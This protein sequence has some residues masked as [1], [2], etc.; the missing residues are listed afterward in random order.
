MSWHRVF[1][2]GPPVPLLCS[3]QKTF[4]NLFWDGHHWLALGVLCLPVAEGGQGLIHLA[5]KVTSMRLQP[6][7]HY[8]TEEPPFFYFLMPTRERVGDSMIL[9]LTGAGIPKWGHLLDLENRRWKLALEVST[10]DWRSLCLV[11]EQG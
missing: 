5:S 8:G 9:A 11:A 10:L 1:V 7:Q 4:V 2:L 3:L 6:D